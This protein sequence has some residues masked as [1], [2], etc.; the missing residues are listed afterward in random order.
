MTRFDEN[1]PFDS[2]HFSREDN[3]P[4]YSADDNDPR[5]DRHF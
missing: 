3:K 5:D 2:Y 4:N 1:C